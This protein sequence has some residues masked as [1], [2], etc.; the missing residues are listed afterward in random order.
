MEDDDDDD[1]DDDDG[2]GGGGDE[3][4]DDDDDNNELRKQHAIENGYG[5]DEED[6]EDERRKQLAIL[7]C[8]SSLQTLM[9]M[10]LCRDTTPPFDE[11]CVEESSTLPGTFLKL[12]LLAVTSL[13]Q[14]EE[15]QC[16]KLQRPG[17][18]WTHIER[19]VS[20]TDS[21]TRDSIWRRK[22]SMSYACFLYLVEE[23]RPFIQSESQMYVRAPLEIERA[24]AMV[25]YRFAHGLSAREVAEKY[26]VGASTVGKYTLIVASAL[27]EANKLYGRYVAIPTGDRIARIISQFQQ[28][29]NVSNM[30]GAIDGTHIKLY[31]KPDKWHN[32]SAYQ[33]P[34]KP[35]SILLQAVCDANKLFWDVCCMAPGGAHDAAHFI[36]SN[37]YQNIKDGLSLQEPLLALENKEVTPYMVGDSAYPIRPFLIKPFDTDDALRRAFDEQLR[38]GSACID[39][40][41]A[42]LKTRWKILKGMNVHLM[43]APRIAVACCVLHNICQLWGEPEPPQQQMEAYSNEQTHGSAAAYEID[44]AAKL[45][46]EASREALFRD[47]VKRSLESPCVSLDQENMYSG[48][49]C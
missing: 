38:K 33:S 3:D 4:S 32:P 2:D 6:A 39:G 25:L 47:W 26:N 14:E 35:H 17:Q 29:T 20:S 11:I 36:A 18:E 46:G 41:F 34:Q 49:N 5:D 15:R 12:M 7:M 48:Q 9:A 24:V 13:M 44:E 1:N 30:C 22:Y 16:W 27:A 40:A 28:I 31:F 19:G 43:H 45:A 23:L 37:L 8:F 10:E 21:A 42:I